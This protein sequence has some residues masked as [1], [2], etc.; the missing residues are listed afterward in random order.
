LI[1]ITAE[2]QERISVVADSLN[3][4]YNPEPASWALA[5]A[6][7][8]LSGYLASLDWSGGP[9]LNWLRRDF[10]PLA[11]QF[12]P[13]QQ[14]SAAGLRLTA[15]QH[16]D[17]WARQ[18]RLWRGEEFAVVDRNWGRFAVLAERAVVVCRYDHNAGAFSVPRQLPLPKVVA[19]SLGL[20][21]GR[22]PRIQLADENG[23]VA[24]TEV[25]SSIAGAL[26]DKLGQY[27]TRPQGS[28]E[29]GTA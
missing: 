19:R 10:D 20:C 14:E 7:G 15:Y 2:S 12:T 24:Y 1:E 23:R 18:H 25:P 3:I 22:P 9:E 16:P 11:Q 4:P 21:S 28:P 8:S 26:L 17:G 6:C 5:S 13:R 27:G 29:D